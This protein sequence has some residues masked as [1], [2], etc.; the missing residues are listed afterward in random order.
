MMLSV[1]SVKADVARD[2]AFREASVRRRMPVRPLRDPKRSRR[3]S[4]H[5]EMPLTPAPAN[6]FNLKMIGFGL[7]TMAAKAGH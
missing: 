7:S 2:R 6:Y 4:E 1:Q 5:A 3:L